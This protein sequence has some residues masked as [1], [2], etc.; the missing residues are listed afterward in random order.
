VSVSV[1]TISPNRRLLHHL[2]RTLLG[3]LLLLLSVGVAR[4]GAQTP[5]APADADADAISELAD[6]ATRTGQL[7]LVFLVDESQSLRRTDPDGRRVQ[8]IQTALAGFAQAADRSARTEAPVAVEV[9]M[10]GFGVGTEEVVGWSPLDGGTLLDLMAA[11]GEFAERDDELDTDYAAALIGAQAQLE[12]AVPAGAA[13]ACTAIVWFTD[14]EYDIEARRA[15]PKDYARDISF[16]D[17]EGAEALEAHG[18]HLLCQGGGLVDGLRTGATAIFAVALSGEIA[19]QDQDFLRAVAEGS[20]GGTT[21]GTPRPPGAT[22]PGLY[23]PVDDLGALLAA[24]N[25]LASEAGGGTVHPGSSEV[26]VCPSQG[27][28]SGTIRFAVD[29]GI[30]GFNLL[31]VTSAEGIEVELRSPEPGAAPLTLTAGAGSGSGSVGSADLR[32]T[33]VAADA[34]LVDATLPESVGAWHGSWSV[35]FIDRTGLSPGAVAAAD[36]YVFGDIEPFVEVGDLRVGEDNVIRVGTRHQAGTPVAADV[37]EDV[38]LE[39]FVVD[40]VDG[41]RHRLELRPPGV[42]GVQEA[43]WSP[44]AGDIPAALNVSAT[45]RV[46]TSSGLALAPVTRS[47]SARVLPP[48]DYPEVSP[49][50]LRLPVITGTDAATV[51]LTVRGGDAVGGCVWVQG[52]QVDQV[53]EEARGMTVA[54]EP[55]ASASSTCFRVDAGQERVLT[56]ALSPEASANGSASGELDIALVSDANP[57]VESQAVA[58]SSRLQKPLDG[59]LAGRLFA[60]LMAAG[61]LLPLILMWLVNLVTGRFASPGSLKCATVAARLGADGKL[62]RTGPG[63]PD[64][65]LQHGN[66]KAVNESGSP[67]R[68]Q[69]G[70]VVL[71][72]RVSWSPFAAPRGE[73][74]AEGYAVDALPTMA[75]RRS[76]GRAPV[77]FGLAG[78]TVVLVAG[79][80]FAAAD[81]RGRRPDVDLTLL[82]FA[83][84]AEVTRYATLLEEQRSAIK[85][86]VDDLW[87]RRPDVPPTPEPEH[88]GDRTPPDPADGWGERPVRT[89]PRPTSSPSAGG[90]GPATPPT[91]AEPDPGPRPR[92]TT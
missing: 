31:A 39:A 57:E 46:T 47:E 40:P 4:A 60:V 33:W 65:A 79:Q 43:I 89:G 53:P 76:P 87:R 24:F 75:G 73:A 51:E 37:F 34:V 16:A 29:P 28:E 44:P 11:S 1:P 71:R 77:A 74:A 69:V 59:E 36:I 12:Q 70:P 68:F 91:R 52:N 35:T 92:R 30:S 26:P 64:L 55:A 45:A 21:C 84:A 22:P 18:K 5:E 50:D 54:S 63:G 72:S 8:A 48:S 88:G 42:D 78:T 9:A 25:R 85:V 2:G 56:L 3:A 86:V 80:S 49:T 90:S 61:I 15:A 23:V 10:V 62:E 58:W 66:F 32:W 83:P 19:P 38:A 6:C 67:R 20:S 81:A 82:V 27:C 17:P 41:A 13:D 7:H 14:G